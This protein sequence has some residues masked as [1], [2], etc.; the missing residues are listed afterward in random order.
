M[1]RLTL[2]VFGATGDLARRKLY[3][4]IAHNIRSGLLPQDT[5]VI[6][7]SRQEMDDVAFGQLVA[8]S[9]GG[10]WPASSR[11]E[12]VAGSADQP[13]LYPDLSQRLKAAPGL[14][15]FYLAVPTHLIS[16]VVGRLADAKLG[17]SRG[18][19]I[20]E[21]P[22]GVDEASARTLNRSVQR[23]FAEGQIYRIDHY[24][25]KETV[26]N[27]LV[28]RFSNGVMEP[29]WN[30]GQIDHVQITAAE[31]IGTEGRSDYYDHAGALRDMVQNHLLQLVA[32][33]AM[34]PPAVFSA[35]AVRDEKVKVLS[36][37]RPVRTE[38]AVR[39]Q[40][41]KGR[42]DGVSVQG[43]QQED[44]VAPDSRRETFAALR[45]FIDNWRWYGVPFYLRTGK[46][47]P[48]RATRIQ[49]V[50]K[51]PPLD[52]FEGAAQA[53]VLSIHVQPDERISLEIG[54]K[55]PG[56]GTHV[57]PVEMN[58]VY[59]SSFR[60]ASAEAYERLLV[61]ATLGDPTLFAREDEVEAAWRALDPLAQRWD[62]EAS[63]LPYAA[64]SWGPQAA[65]A[66]IARDGRHWLDP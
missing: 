14:H 59:A 5:T 11:L 15:L 21:K 18:R 38:D 37:I 47:L 28:F 54:A 31:T 49:V 26:Q 66:L 56:L 9:I 33:T 4:A 58:F 25:G 20:V 10:A 35:Q 24:L 34:E 50:F 1:T 36:A 64:G 30:R 7:I 43:Y 2:I 53:N 29:L 3:A 6:G 55:R 22:F 16:A 23:A 44:G 52:L 48:E 42:I 45:L 13:D 19:V 17:R 65:T 61:D 32:L 46:R 51:Q 27:I 41:Q 39:G 63:C 40:Y 12:Y 57:D 62:K 60:S 8:E